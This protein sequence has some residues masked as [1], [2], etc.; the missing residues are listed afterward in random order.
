MSVARRQQIVFLVGVFSVACWNAGCHRN[1][2]PN[3]YGA[4]YGQSG[5]GQPGYATP[6]STPGSNVAPSVTLPPPPGQA[7]SLPPPPGAAGALPPISQLTPPPGALPGGTAAPVG[8]P[9][10][11]NPGTMSQQ[12]QRA[13]VFD[14]YSD[15]N[16]GPEIVGGRPREFQKPTA[17]PARYNSLNGFGASRSP[18]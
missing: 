16:A 4:P 15:N 12:Q 2:Y 1:T 14:P 9:N 18:F 17:E 5:S 10:W 11:G 13:K 8:R 3:P 6:W 7:G